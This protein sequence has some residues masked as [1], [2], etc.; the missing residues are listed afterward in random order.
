LYPEA[1]VPVLQMSLPDLDPAHLFA[2]G[3]RLAPLRDEASWWSAA[4][5]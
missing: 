2:I 1:D 3:Q 4:A 5:S